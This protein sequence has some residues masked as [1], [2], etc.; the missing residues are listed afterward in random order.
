MAQ[1][2]QKSLVY[3]ELKALEEQKLLDIEYF[4][5]KRKKL[6]NVYADIIP[7]YPATDIERIVGNFLLKLGVNFQFQYHLANFPETA[8]PENIWV[9]D[10]VLPDYNIVLEVYGY[11]WHS[12][13]QRRDA[14]QL[15]KLYFLAKGY[16]VFE[17]GRVLY[18][19]DTTW[20]G[21]KL[22]IWWDYEI[23]ADLMYL[24]NRDIPE[25][26]IRKTLIELPQVPEI[27]RMEAIETAEAQRAARITKRIVPKMK[28]FKPLTLKLR[29]YERRSKHKIPEFL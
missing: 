26:L 25:I 18:P 29:R 24:V 9:P 4:K 17:N 12:L 6:E 16:A 15:K 22:V 20:N 19:S 2:P 11:Y 1:Y 28:P 3:S 23:Y 10:F 14:D 13:P 8:F 27:K 21:G 5:Y 7:F